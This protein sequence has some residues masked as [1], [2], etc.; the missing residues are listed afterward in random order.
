MRPKESGYKDMA[1]D[2]FRT[3]QTGIEDTIKSQ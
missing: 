3:Q 1:Q 2:L